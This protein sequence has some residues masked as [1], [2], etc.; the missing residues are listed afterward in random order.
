[1]F[2]ERLLI[3]S[4]PPLRE[5]VNGTFF[6][7]ITVSFLFTAVCNFFVERQLITL[8]KITAHTIGKIFFML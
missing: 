4:F 5:S 8:I 2:L 6:T 3:R 1:M 7:V